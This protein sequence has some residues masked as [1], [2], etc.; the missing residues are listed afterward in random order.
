MNS[1]NQIIFSIENENTLR[2][3]E[4]IQK[5]YINVTK[6]MIIQN[7]LFGACNIWK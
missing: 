6:A 7:H 1:A 4:L 5:Y 3:T 2:I